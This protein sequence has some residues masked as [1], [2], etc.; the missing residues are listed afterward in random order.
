MIGTRRTVVEFNDHQT[1][2]EDSLR[3]KSKTQKKANLKSR[4]S[5]NHE[6]SFS[7]KTKK[8][9][10][11]RFLP[12]CVETF[13]KEERNVEIWSVTAICLYNPRW[14]IL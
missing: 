3:H 4:L 8:V 11:L 7:S 5:F 12:F 1:D 6:S 13:P 2:P 9:S 14:I 10:S